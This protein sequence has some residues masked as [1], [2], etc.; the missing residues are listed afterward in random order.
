MANWTIINTVTKSYELKATP[1]E[2]KDLLEEVKTFEGEN[3][4]SYNI[5]LR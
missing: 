3:G 2:I 1:Y 5:L 4:Y